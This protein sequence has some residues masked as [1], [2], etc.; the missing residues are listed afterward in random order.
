MIELK[1]L[2]YFI[3][4]AEHS[5]FVQAA[6]NL[7][8]TQPALSRAIAKLE[9][10]LGASL[11]ERTTRSIRLTAAGQEL[12]RRAI[13]LLHEANGL[14]QAV[15]E[16]SKNGL[17]RQT[18]RICLEDD[19]Y[20]LEGSGAFELI[21]KIRMNFPELAVECIPAAASSF[22]RILTEGAADLTIGYA[23]T[24]D[25]KMANG[26]MDRT[27]S[28]GRIA[29]AVPCDWDC[30]LESPR[31]RELVSGADF[32]FPYDRSG[33]APTIRTL[34]DH[35]GLSPKYCALENYTA[36]I[37]FVASGSGMFAAPEAQ[38]RRYEPLVRI[39]PMGVQMAEYRVVAASRNN[40]T[41]GYVQRIMDFIGEETA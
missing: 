22:A 37:N 25:R 17:T 10:E 16:T 33:W 32:F 7:Y 30:P 39:V 34:L 26:L 15:K 21:A 11:V 38:L 27:I 20:S 18:L 14:T 35:Y 6:Q 1:Q 41:A 29:L 12:Y 36:V 8:I 3:A 28:F 31:F 13:G 4:V 24:G 2:R 19:L 40:L 23:A 5:S 9:E